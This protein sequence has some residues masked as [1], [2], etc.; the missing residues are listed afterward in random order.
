LFERQAESL[1][2]STPLGAWHYATVLC[3]IALMRSG[4]WC[5]IAMCTRS[6]SHLRR[7]RME[8]LRRNGG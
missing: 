7:R 3:R 2:I 6:S 5:A 1:D 4:S 8:D